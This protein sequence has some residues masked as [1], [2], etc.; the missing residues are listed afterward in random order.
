MKESEGTEEVTTFPPLL[1]TAARTAGRPNE[2]YLLDYFS[3]KCIGFVFIM[4][5]FYGQPVRSC[6]KQAKGAQGTRF[7]VLDILGKEQHGGPVKRQR[8]SAGGALTLA[9]NRLKT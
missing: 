2:T 8:R 7:S 1:L 4:A 9:I 5:N 3:W 6:W